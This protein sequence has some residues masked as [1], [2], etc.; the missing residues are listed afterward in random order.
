VSGAG[1]SPS[2]AHHYPEVNEGLMAYKIGTHR[3]TPEIE[4]VGL[5]GKAVT[6]SYAHLIPMN[7]GS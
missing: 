4:Q 3:H 6:I 7:G 1:R 5:A 2:L